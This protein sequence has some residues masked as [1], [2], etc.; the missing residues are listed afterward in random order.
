M[1][2][3]Q[4]ALVRV[5]AAHHGGRVAREGT[6]TAQFWAPGRD[7][8]ADPS[9]GSSPDLLVPLAWSEAQRAWCALVPT[10][11]WAPGTW[12]MRGS[13]ACPDLENVVCLGWAWAVLEL[14]A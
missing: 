3:G 7:P 14:A 1:Q 11:G 10:G 4:T 13:A 12:V 6:V 5:K 8:R 2:A 9:L